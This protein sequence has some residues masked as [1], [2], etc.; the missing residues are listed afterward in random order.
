MTVTP[1][2]SYLTKEL[3]YKLAAALAGFLNNVRANV[4]FNSPTYDYPEKSL[5]PPTPIGAR[6]TWSL[7]SGR[8]TNTA[9]T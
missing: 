4:G 7:R 3:Q 2:Q 1:N 8:A 6:T 5:V 9:P